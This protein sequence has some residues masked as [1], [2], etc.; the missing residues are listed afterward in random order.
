LTFTVNATDPVHATCSQTAP[1]L[2]AAPAATVALL[3]EIDNTL[4]GRITEN[5]ALTA[6]AELNV[7]VH[8]PVP[9]QPAPDQPLKDEPDAALAVSVTVAPVS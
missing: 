6:W 3:E 4:T 5:V 8:V 7:T 9:L 1:R 2:N